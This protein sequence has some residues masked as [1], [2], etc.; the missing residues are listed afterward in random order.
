MATGKLITLKN[1]NIRAILTGLLINHT[2]N[3]IS[4]ACN[5]NINC[6]SC[7]KSMI[8]RGEEGDYLECEGCYKTISCITPNKHY[9]SYCGSTA[10]GQVLPSGKYFC[11]KCSHETD[12]Q[13]QEIS[14]VEH[15]YH[16]TQ[17]CVLCG[18]TFIVSGET[19]NLC[20][21]C[22]LGTDNEISR[23]YEEDYLSTLDDFGYHDD[24]GSYHRYDE[25]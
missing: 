22:K 16:K 25:E 18:E 6:P 3:V 8:V 23:G 24:S 15:V 14:K 10:I 1:G 19:T 12:I 2:D 4:F 9:C 11:A 17:E 20:P 13:N 21:S 7:N 5:T